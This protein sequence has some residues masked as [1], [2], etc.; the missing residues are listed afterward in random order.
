MKVNPEIRKT[1]VS[2]AENAI[3]NDNSP[4]ENRAM[5]RKLVRMF[6]HHLTEEEQIY[7]L[8]TILEFV[9]YRNIATDPD[10]LLTMHNIK[11]RSGMF[12]FFM[13]VGF[14]VLVSVLF[15][16]NNSL[17]AIGSIL[18]NVLKLISM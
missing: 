4:D 12:I 15:Q 14:T 6:R 1:L 18:G 17:A 11:L 5:F 7:V 3:D 10:N 8:K 13:A 16:S 9:H 2:I